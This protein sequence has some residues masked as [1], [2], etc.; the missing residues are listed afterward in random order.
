M[1]RRWFEGGLRS[2]TPDASPRGGDSVSL[3]LPALLASGGPL[4]D[5]QALAKAAQACE[6]KLRAAPAAAPTSTPA[7]PTGAVT[8]QQGAGGAAA[9]AGPTSGVSAG[10]LDPRER[11]VV[12]LPAAAA[13]QGGRATAAGAGSGAAAGGEEVTLMRNTSW[14]VEGVL[15]GSSTPKRP[16]Q[17]RR[18]AWGCVWAHGTK[19]IRGRAHG[20]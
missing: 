19:R 5:Q 10:P 16:E 12:R 9:L 8:P 17:V 18:G 4:L 2:A 14:V 1:R 11:A 13:A 7:L 3:L 15:M 6:R 20:R